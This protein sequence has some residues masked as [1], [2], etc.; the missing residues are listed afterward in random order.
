W[1]PLGDYEASYKAG[2]HERKK[3]KERFTA[4][5]AQ[6]LVV[7][8]NSMNLMVFT[9]LLKQTKIKIDTAISGDA[10]IVLTQK[11]KYDVIFLDHMMPDKDG[12]ET[13]Q[14]LRAQKDNPNCRTVSVCL[15]ANAISGA[16]EKYIAA[17]FDNYLTK[18]INPDKLEEMLLEYLPAE[19]V[20]ATSNVNP[21]QTD[22]KY[23]NID[24][25]L[26]Y[27]DGM[28]DLFRSVVEIF[29]NLKDDK[30]EKIQ[31]AFESGNWKDYTIFVHALK[32]TALSIGGEQTAK[33]AK[34][35]EM[36]GN[37]L[38]DVNSTESDKR[39]AESFIKAHHAEAM[40]LYDKLVEEGNRY[41]N[42]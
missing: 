27:S 23:M 7:D 6:V 32:S 14:E 4:P 18:P 1:E 30:K 15:T 24:M 40:E 31:R 36:A 29:C 25:G 33:I 17:G 5:S 37:V 22:Y 42:S 21:S 28:E 34:E 8:D 9:N 20:V 12:I 19:K 39:E 16:R 35:L 26:K 38:R 2:L 13:L 11:N 10:G 3:Y 41:L